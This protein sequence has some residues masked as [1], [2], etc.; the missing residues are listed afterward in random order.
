MGSSILNSGG[1]EGCATCFVFTGLYIFTYQH[2]IDD[3]VGEGIEQSKWADKISQCVNVTCDYEEF[4]AKEDTSSFLVEPWFETS[5]D[6]LNYAV[7][8]LKENG[9]QEPSGLYNRIA[10]VPSS[11]LVCIVG[12]HDIKQKLSD[13]C[14]VISQDEHIQEREAGDGSVTVQ[15][16]Y[17]YTQKVP[18]KQFINLNCVVTCDNTFYCG[19]SGSPVFDSKGSLVAMHTAGFIYEYE[20]GVSNIIKFGS[21]MKCI[22][23]D[24]KQKHKTWYDEEFVN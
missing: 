1:K 5:D 12:H 19:S 16:I 8:K 2:G 4:L 23:S 3:I 13:G 14:V 7:L 18:K 20:S 9:Q 22:L 24:I 10:P 15:Y 17:V 6:I 21:S 11:G